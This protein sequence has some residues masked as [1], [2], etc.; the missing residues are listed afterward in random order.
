MALTLT[1]AQ[2]DEIRRLRD[3]GPL[4]QTTANPLG[5]YSHIYRYISEQL[6][7]SDEKNWFLGATQANAG[8]GAY[9]AMIRGYS[10]RQMELRGIDV[11][12]TA[13]LAELMQAA[14]NRVAENA[15]KDILGENPATTANRDQH[16]G[17]W[18]FPTIDEIASRDAIGVGEVLFASLPAGDTARGDT[19]NAGWAGTI[20]FS[21]LD[22]AQTWRLTQGGGIGLNSLDDAKNILF[23]YDALSTGLKAAFAAGF[24][25][26]FKDLKILGMTI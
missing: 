11:S 1:Q 2:I 16:N 10:K 15:L 5:D 14:S 23:A 9:S 24:D 13:A 8:N 18:T 25:Q 7:S 12:N 3:A 19:F 26:P 17:Y 6:G 20:L 22:S 21:P 4:N